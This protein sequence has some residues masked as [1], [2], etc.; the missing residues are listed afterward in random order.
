MTTGRVI[1][2]PEVMNKIGYSTAWIYRFISRGVFPEPIKIGIRASVFVE[3]EI[4]EWIE[5]V[6]QLS[7]KHND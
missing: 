4:D 6:I 3:S 5:N 2:L 1:R 7:R